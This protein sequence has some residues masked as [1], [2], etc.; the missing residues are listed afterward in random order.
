M[1]NVYFSNE[2]IKHLINSYE[3]LNEITANTLLIVGEIETEVFADAYGDGE[4]VKSP[5]TKLILSDSIL[6]VYNHM[7][8]FLDDEIELIP[9]KNGVVYY[10]LLQWEEDINERVLQRLY[11]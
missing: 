6:A 8:I 3:G 1:D 10:K 7:G 4:F 5:K 11:Y 2:T 9:D